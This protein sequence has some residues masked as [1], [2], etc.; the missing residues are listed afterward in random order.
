MLYD[1]YA[2]PESFVRRGL[3]LTTIFL[4]NVE[5][6]DLNTTKTGNYRPA[7]EMPFPWRADDGSAL[8]ADLVAL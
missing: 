4:V 7:R 8:N 5:K 3:T 2:D 1:S 6:E